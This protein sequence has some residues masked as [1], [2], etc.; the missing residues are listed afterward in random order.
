M[1]VFGVLVFLFLPFVAGFVLRWVVQAK[2]AMGRT[3]LAIS[4]AC[5]PVVWLLGSAEFGDGITNAATWALASVVFMVF[6]VPA[7]LGVHLAS[8]RKAE[9]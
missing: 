6:L 9:Q 8:L 1:E 4:G 5:L 3:S 7:A 2:S